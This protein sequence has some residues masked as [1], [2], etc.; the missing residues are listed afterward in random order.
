MLHFTNFIRKVF[1]FLNV[2][3]CVPFSFPGEIYLDLVLEKFRIF[4][5]LCFK[6]LTKHPEEFKSNHIRTK[7][8]LAGEI[9]SFVNEIETLGFRLRSGTN[10]VQR[11]FWCNLKCNQPEVKEI[12]RSLP[13]PNDKNPNPKIQMTKSKSKSKMQPS[14][15]ED[16][17]YCSV[18]SS[19]KWQKN[20]NR[21]FF[22]FLTNFL[23]MAGMKKLSFFVKSLNSRKA[24]L[25]PKCQV[26]PS[27]LL[28]FREQ[29]LYVARLPPDL[30]K[31]IWH[32]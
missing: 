5:T 4:R 9:K 22:C 25:N 6:N 2:F 7:E 15:G 23:S 20:I 26:C 19:S 3:G 29:N 1:C 11:K 18:S 32:L 14:L 21:D 24:L 16:A 28:L 13:H 17:G 30:K 8:D 12:V 27:L 31:W 10:R